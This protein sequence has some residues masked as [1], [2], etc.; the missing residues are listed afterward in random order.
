MASGA[1]SRGLAVGFF[2]LQFL[3]AVREAVV[4]K[5]ELEV[6]FLLIRREFDLALDGGFGVAFVA[7]FNSVALFPSILAVFVDM[8][9]LITG[10]LV[11]LRMLL[12]AEY[13]GRFGQR[14]PKRRFDGDFVGRLLCG[15]YQQRR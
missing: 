1:G 11:L 5:C 8:M 2:R 7:F 6:K 10:D 13:H 14:R 4:V 3:V 12:V 15:P 9:A